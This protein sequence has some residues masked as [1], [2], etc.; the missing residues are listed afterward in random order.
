MTVLFNE[1]A[2]ILSLLAVTIIVSLI[3]G[4]FVIIKLCKENDDLR[5]ANERQR[6]E[7]AD[8]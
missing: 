4:L 2:V 3:G 6:R 7:Q 8:N 5:V 1:S